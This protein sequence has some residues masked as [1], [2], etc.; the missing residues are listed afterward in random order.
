[1]KTGANARF[2]LCFQRKLAHIITNRYILESKTSLTPKFEVE[3][4]EN[5]ADMEKLAARIFS[6]AGQRPLT[7]LARPV[8]APQHRALT[9]GRPC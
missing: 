3:I 4:K 2:P 9:E 1:M 7:L 8:T 6:R 5:E